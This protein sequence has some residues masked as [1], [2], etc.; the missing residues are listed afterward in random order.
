[1]RKQIHYMHISRF[2]SQIVIDSLLLLL[3]LCIVF[4]RKK[5]EM[6]SYLL[7]VRVE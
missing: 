1:M 7:C 4:V 2:D 3:L 6:I 5:K